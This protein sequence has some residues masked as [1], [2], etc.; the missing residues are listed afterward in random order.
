M[1]PAPASRRTRSSSALGR[2]STARSHPA[3]LLQDVHQGRVGVK[4]PGAAGHGPAQGGDAVIDL[5]QHLAGDLVGRSGQVGVA[6]ARG[7]PAPF[8]GEGQKDLQIDFAVGRGH[9][10]RVVDEIGVDAPAPP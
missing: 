10:G 9:A 2:T 7:Q 6:L 1:R 5:T 3:R 4:F 8:D